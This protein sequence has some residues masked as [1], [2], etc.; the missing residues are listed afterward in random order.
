MSETYKAVVNGSQEFSLLRKEIDALDAVSET[1]NALHLLQD[2][3]SVTV[4]VISKDLINRTYTI[5]VNGNR[6]TVHIE[7][8]LD[9]LIAEMGLSLGANA[10]ENEIHAPMPGLILE[11]NVKEG[12]EV[13]Q[14]DP[15]CV[16][17][18]MKMENALGAPS[19]GVV[20]TVHIATGETVGKNA[21]LIELED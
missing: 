18:A 12:D 11:V 10:V 1:K 13:S 20:K 19:D 15:L 9:A 5:K 8:E 6:Y 17:E 2:N 4:N 3:K 21:L 16:L 14:G 7:T